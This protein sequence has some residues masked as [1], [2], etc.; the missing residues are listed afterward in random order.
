MMLSELSGRRH[1]WGM[2]SS[3][4]RRRFR[5]Y[6]PWWP[7]GLAGTGA[8]I[9]AVV[10]TIRRTGDDHGIA[11][12]LAVVCL[13][14]GLAGLVTGVIEGVL[15]P[16][17]PIQLRIRMALVVVALIAAAILGGGALAAGAAVLIGSGV[18]LGSEW[19]GLVVMS[20]LL[21][22]PNDNGSESPG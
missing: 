3:G 11:G 6:R 15:Q 16:S 9:V 12:P 21:P 20:T 10:E 18:A 4:F 1:T 19:C 2:R 7:L 5:R 17:A 13:I 8:I 22:P 14:A